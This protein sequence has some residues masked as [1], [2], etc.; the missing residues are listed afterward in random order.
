VAGYLN[1]RGIWLRLVALYSTCNLLPP[2]L[3]ARLVRDSEA[4]HFTT[5]EWTLRILK[6]MV[7]GGGFLDSHPSSAFFASPGENVVWIS[8]SSGI[9]PESTCTR[10]AAL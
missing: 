7:A 5:C 9:A 8:S 3:D 6:L 10:R 4:I 2:C 1:A